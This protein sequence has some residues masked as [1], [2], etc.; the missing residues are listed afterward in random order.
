MLPGGHRQG[1]C[2]IYLVTKNWV[3]LIEHISGETNSLY[4]DGTATNTDIGGGNLGDHRG[5]GGHALT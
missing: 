2:L 3:E 4:G 5:R 1:A